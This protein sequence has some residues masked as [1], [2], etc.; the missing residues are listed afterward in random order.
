MALVVNGSEQFA[1]SVLRAVYGRPGSFTAGSH[2]KAADG[3]LS[4]FT[5]LGDTIGLGADAR[6]SITLEFAGVP[7][8]E[9]Q[10]WALMALGLGLVG[11][12]A[13][14]RAG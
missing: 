13:R 8:P 9:P 6:M 14:R 12:A 4:T 7:V 1:T 2:V 3:V 5:Q 10:T 11:A